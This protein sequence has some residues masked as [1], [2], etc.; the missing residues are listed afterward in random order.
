MASDSQPSHPPRRV[1]V[2]GAGSAGLAAAYELTQRDPALDVAVFDP[3]PHAGGK[4]RTLRKQGY[5]IELG[6]DGFITIKHNVLAFIERIGLTDQLIKTNPDGAGALVV[7]KGKLVPIPMGFQ[8]LGPSQLM[9]FMR[10]PLLSPLGKLRVMCEPMIRGRTDD[11]DESLASFIRRRFGSELLERLVQPLAGGIY[12]ADPEHLSMRCTFPRFVEMERKH[13]SVVRGL[14]R[15]LKA[16]KSGGSGGGATRGARYGLFV[17]LKDGMDTLPNR[18]V[19]L[20][21]PDKL[22]L[23]HRVTELS[24]TSDQ[25]WRLRD[26]RGTD[27]IFDAVIATCAA[28]VLGKLLQPVDISIGS[29]LGAVPHTSSAVATLCYETDQL[30]TPPKAFGFV[31][32]AVEK[33]PLIAASFTSVKYAGRA[34]EGSILIRVF[35]GSAIDDTALGQD[36]DALIAS[37]HDQLTQ[38]LGVTG[39]PALS[40][41]DRYVGSMPQYHVGHDEKIAALRDALGSLPRIELA[42]CGYDGVGIPDTL[43]AGVKAADKILASIHPDS[44]TA[45]AS[46]ASA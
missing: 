13:G 26:D 46:P 8:L 25:R 14:K 35:L 3:S 18:L 23:T 6:P 1:A 11:A 40:R 24:P 41:L 29:Q 20:I 45:A 38:L 17:S 22:R 30:P 33:R 44:P 19:E 37:A 39:Q 32:P 9:S 21:G 10:T 2:I 5:I 34:P 28:P 15:G 4:I 42:G 12:T 7:H 27:E 16:Q 31:V 36:D 43:A